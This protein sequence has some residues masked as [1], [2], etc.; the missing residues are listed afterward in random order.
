MR[1][2]VIDEAGGPD[3]MVLREVPDPT[4]RAGEVVVDVRATGVNF[5]DVLLR[6]GTYPGGGPA[7]WTPG[8]EVAGDI[9]GRAVIALPGANGYASRVAVDERFVFDLPA[10]RSHVEGAALLLASLTAWLP[11]ARRI[12]PGSTL[13]VTSAAGGVGTAAIQVGRLLGARV[14]A[15]ASTADRLAACRRLGADVTVDYAT[16]DLAAA[17][18]AAG[19]ADVALDM[20]GGATLVACIEAL[21]PRGV[22]IA[23]GAP[24]GDW[25]PVSP[26]LLVGR[27]AGLEGFFLG[28]LMRLAPAEVREAALHVISLWADGALAPVVSHVLPLADAPDAHRLLEERRSVGK[29]VL[30]P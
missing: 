15:A 29:V 8:L 20:V 2:I 9:E 5:A 21:R 14:I 23:V 27:N 1:A 30:E 4:P 26:A 25:A 19:G 24:D 6:R 13:L 11:L 3:R 17:V 22:A 18:K 10:G 28:R 7:P 16:E 12:V